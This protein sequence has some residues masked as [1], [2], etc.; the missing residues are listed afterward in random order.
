VFPA[1][2]K[3]VA[4]W[5]PARER[6]LATGMFNAGSNLGA[7]LTPLLVP[8]IASAF[9]W[10][11]A[12]VFTGALGFGWI[13]LW[14]AVYRAPEKHPRCSQEELQTIRGGSAEETRTIAWKSL[15]G[16]RQTWT[17]V[18]VKFLVDPIW[19][20][21]LFWIPDFL[22]RSYGLD[23]MHI[24]LPIVV[25]YL[26]SD[27]GSVAGGWLSSKLIA[28]GMS[29]N[30]SRKLAMLIC[31]AAALPVMFVYRLTNLWLAVILLGIAAAAHQGYSANLYTVAS[32]LF[33]KRAVASI[34]G[35]S[36]MAAGIGGMFIAKLVGYVLQWSGSYMVPF[37]IA[38]C[39]YSVALIVLQVMSPRLR[40][41][42][43]EA[44]GM[45]TSRGSL[46]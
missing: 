26:I 12:F 39:S 9:G 19:W 29:V 37:V 23:L 16:Y 7:V 3:T 18:C 15:F 21:Y 40:P 42:E 13:V 44:E 22:H 8:W 28:S 17:M 1:G 35:L 32:D 25:V 5:F 11:W 4:E 41:V 43:V 24:G 14:L 6:A 46:A 27:V 38:G 31:A 20:F 36:G 10:R 34:I 45:V 30:R 33:P 2:I